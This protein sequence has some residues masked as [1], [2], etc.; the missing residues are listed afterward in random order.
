[1]VD[2][3]GGIIRQQRHND[4]FSACVSMLTGIDLDVLPVC[5]PVKEWSGQHHTQTGES[6]YHFSAP[7]FHGWPELL[8]ELGYKVE[9]ADDR[10]DQY[11]YIVDVSG[12]TGDS[13]DSIASHALV[14]VGDG[15][16]ADPA[17]GSVITD[18]DF[19]EVGYFTI[20]PA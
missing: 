13:W 10:P 18:A 1:M 16:W 4:C 11:P 19:I 2:L 6:V 3:P 14:A 20:R 15:Q 17:K 9:Q 12:I 7:D 5:P 8:A